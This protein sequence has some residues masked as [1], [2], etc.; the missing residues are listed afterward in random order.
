MKRAMWTSMAVISL[1]ACVACGGDD[2]DDDGGSVTVDTGL[3]ESKQLGTL[4]PAELTQLCQG[5]SAAD[6]K[7]SSSTAAKDGACR[8]EAIAAIVAAAFQTG[9]MPADDAL[10]QQ[11]NDAY[12]QCMQRPAAA[13]TQKTCQSDP[14]CTATVGEAETCY[15]A[16]LKIAIESTASLPSCSDL[17][18]A[19]AQETAGASV[20]P[21]TAGE[22]Q[23]VAQKCPNFQVVVG[24]G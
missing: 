10:Q 15:A 13:Q 7:A 14:T 6:Q 12:N 21:Q 16:N 1:V 20:N 23:A 4:T 11:C 24:S 17:T 5:L 9:A 18:G 2:D 3:D 19:K 22:C 8:G